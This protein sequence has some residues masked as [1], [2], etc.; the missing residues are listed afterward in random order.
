MIAV[1]YVYVSGEYIV[2]YA[3]ECYPIPAHRHRK[4]RLWVGRKVPTLDEFNA[5]VQTSFNST[6][7]LS[8]TPGHSIV[9]VAW[10]EFLT[11]AAYLML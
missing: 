4:R 9:R 7:S 10:F 6:N 8:Y 3:F 1:Y 11:L 5:Q 2:N